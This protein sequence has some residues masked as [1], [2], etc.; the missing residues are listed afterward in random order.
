M[1]TTSIQFHGPMSP[2]LWVL[3]LTIGTVLIFVPRF[4]SLVVQS[5]SGVPPRNSNPREQAEGKEVAA[6]DTHG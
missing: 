4:T 2:S 3:S 1:K 5:K 6:K